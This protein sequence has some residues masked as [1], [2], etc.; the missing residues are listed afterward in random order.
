MVNLTPIWTTEGTWV[1]P[2][3]WQQGRGAWGGLVTGQVLTA[4]V[5]VTAERPELVPRSLYVAM[6]GP[7]P[8]GE[9]SVSVMQLRAGRSTVSHEVT[10]RS[11]AGSVLTR[12]TVISGRRRTPTPVSAR[13]AD[14]PAPPDPTAAS[15]LAIGPPMAPVFTSQLDFRPVSGFPFSGVE[16]L[17]CEGWVGLGADSTETL[18]APII[19]ALIDAYWTAAIVGLDLAAAAEGIPFSTLDF[20]MHFPSEPPAITAADLWRTGLWHTSRVTGGRDGYLTEERM[21]RA[22]SGEVLATNSQLLAVGR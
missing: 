10:L 14:L 13:V 2:D 11:P 7:V 19:A 4:V 12:A 18:T 1:V 22:A 21:L 5:S 9:V 15:T 17:S 20:S 6:L 3:G 8:T 16:E